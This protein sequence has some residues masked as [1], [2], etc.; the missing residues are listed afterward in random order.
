MSW[1]NPG[2]TFGASQA[3]YAKNKRLATI[4]RLQEAKLRQQQSAER[5]QMEAAVEELDGSP[6][7]E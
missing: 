1:G 6:D 3:R 7:D 5:R 4:R 2:M